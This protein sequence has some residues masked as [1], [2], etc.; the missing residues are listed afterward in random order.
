MSPLVFHFHQLIF[1]SY[2]IPQTLQFSCHYISHRLFSYPR[3]LE[4]KPTL[5]D[6]YY[7][8][9]TVEMAL[10]VRINPKGCQALLSHNDTIDDLKAH[11]WDVFLMKFE[12][13]NLSVSQAFA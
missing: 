3:L 1:P 10:V 7:I 4:T 5:C 11:V 6:V 2:D 8:L 12:G 13:Y 9:F